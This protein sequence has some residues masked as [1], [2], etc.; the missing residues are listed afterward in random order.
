[1]LSPLE[2]LAAVKVA[3]PGSF[4]EY[5]EGSMLT[6]NAG[7]GKKAIQEASYTL[8]EEGLVLLISKKVREEIHAY[9][10]VRTKAPYVENPSILNRLGELERMAR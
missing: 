3:K 9:Y 2:L 4:I 8:Y 6:I 7:K 1:M 10:A 5:Y